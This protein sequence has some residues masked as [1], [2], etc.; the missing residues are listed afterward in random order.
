MTLR[1]DPIRRFSAAHPCPICGGHDG[2]PRGRS[3]RCFGYFDGSGRFAR[4]TRREY[5]GTLGQ[6]PDE[7]CSY[8]LAGECRCGVVHG[9]FTPFP[10][11]SP[12][13]RRQPHGFPTRDAIVAYLRGCYGFGAILREWAYQD[14]EGRDVFRVLRVDY[15]SD[16]GGLMKTYRPFHRRPDGTWALGSPPAHWPLYGLPDLVSANPS[17]TI[18]VV[19]GEKCAEAAR[20]LGL[21]GVTTS[22][23]GARAAR[24]SDWSLLAGR[25]VVLLPDHDSEGGRYV[26]EV[27]AMLREFVP[28]ARSR[29]VFLPGLLEGEDLIQF[30][31]RRRK[32]GRSDRQILDEVRALIA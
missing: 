11:S 8:F 24:E 6:N 22:A 3:V 21:L 26:A 15:R 27:V 2:L 31:A 4:C 20:T 14:A 9:T 5:A 1:R 30:I 16:D 19:E 13:E 28:T 32:R 18:T 17:E 12:P 23:H 29:I 7:T 25:A 10:S